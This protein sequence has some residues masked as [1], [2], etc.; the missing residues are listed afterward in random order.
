[1]LPQPAADGTLVEVV[2]VVEQTKAVRVVLAG[3]ETVPRL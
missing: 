2:P 3:Q 1:M